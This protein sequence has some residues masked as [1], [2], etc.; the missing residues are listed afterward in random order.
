MT[1]TRK[2]VTVRWSRLLWAAACVVTAVLLLALAGPA[3]AET[4]PA[5]LEKMQKSLENSVSVYERRYGEGSP[6]ARFYTEELLDTYEASYGVRLSNPLGSMTVAEKRSVAVD[7]YQGDLDAQEMRYPRLYGKGYLS[8]KKLQELTDQYNRQYGD[9]YG[10]TF[11]NPLGA[12]TELDKMKFDVEQRPVLEARYQSEL[13]KLRTYADKRW[14][15]DSQAAKN[16]VQNYKS[17]YE[18][19][20]SIVLENPYVG[21]TTEEMGALAQQQLDNLYQ[22]LTDQG[23]TAQEI[24]D[25]VDTLRR[26]Y[27]SKYGVALADPA[28]TGGASA[29]ELVEGATP[30]HILNAYI[31]QSIRRLGGIITNERPVSTYVGNDYQVAAGF[32]K[33]M[34]IFDRRLLFRPPIGFPERHRPKKVAVI[35][36]EVVR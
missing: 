32:R 36:K 13:E 29:Q 4:D 2:N 31:K 9:K 3:R 24:Q 10:I 16:Y 21:P 19:K 35:S 15:K 5:L 28:E 18:R 34:S 22:Y 30:D 1:S 23:L 33:G 11:E 25:R 27:E 17:Y 26:Y 14:G 12:P 20:F 7:I 6:K 8:K